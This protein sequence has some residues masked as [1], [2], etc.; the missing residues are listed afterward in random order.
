MIQCDELYFNLLT[1]YAVPS[2]TMQEKYTYPWNVP[3]RAELA[4]IDTSDMSIDGGKDA[5]MDFLQQ[6]AVKLTCEPQAGDDEAR[7]IYCDEKMSAQAKPKS[8]RAGLMWNN[9]LKCTSIHTSPAHNVVVSRLVDVPH[10][11]VCVSD[12]GDMFLVR[13]TEEGYQCTVTGKIGTVWNAAI[14]FSVANVHGM[15]VIV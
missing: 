5:L 8:Q 9:S 6:N 1:I 3:Y 12:R 4:Q 15:Q 7:T 10:D 13:S 11:L 2:A 14:D